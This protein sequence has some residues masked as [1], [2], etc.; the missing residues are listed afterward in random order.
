MGKRKT[1]TKEDTAVQIYFFGGP[2]DGKTLRVVNPPPSRMRLA[3][4]EWCNY[5]R[6]GKTLD[7]E[8][9]MTKPWVTLNALVRE[10]D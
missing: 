10:N 8:Y 6:K 7:Y 9:D 3:F 4:P 1:K 5:Y 2:R